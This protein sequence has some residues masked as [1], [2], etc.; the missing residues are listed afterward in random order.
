MGCAHGLNTFFVSFFTLRFLYTIRVQFKYI[1]LALALILTTSCSKEPPVTTAVTSVSGAR[2]AVFF[3]SQLLSAGFLRTGVGRPSAPIG[4]IPSNFLLDIS[5]AP[6]A[7]ARMGVESVA[8]LLLQNEV[9]TD[10]SFTI[11]RQ[12]GVVLEV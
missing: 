2:S 12:L 3:T 7:A 11:L 10:L 4:V 6:V 9:S 1:S 8:R 5:A